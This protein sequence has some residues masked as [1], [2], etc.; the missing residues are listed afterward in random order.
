MLA[1]ATKT[2]KPRQQAKDLTEWPMDGSND[3][4]LPKVGDSEA[5]QEK[6]AEAVDLLAEKLRESIRFGYGRAWVY[7]FVDDHELGAIQ[8]GSQDNHK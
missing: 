2:R 5:N 6:F 8:P 3:R 4:R 1:A 7:V